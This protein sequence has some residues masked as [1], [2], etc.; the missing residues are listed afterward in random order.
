[1][2]KL[3]FSRFLLICVV[4]VT[5]VASLIFF[6]L[7]E[8]RI[9]Q[10]ISQYI[11]NISLTVS[12]AMSYPLSS[13]KNF[14]SDFNSV[15]ELRKENSK[16]NEKL[17]ILEPNEKKLK[18]LI[19]ENE[20]LRASLDIKNSFA[21]QTVLTGKVINRST[22]AWLDWI[23]LDVGHEDGVF[24][25]M[26]VLSNG[27]LIGKITQV[28]SKFSTVDLLTNTGKSIEI[29]IKISTSTGD[30]YGILTGFDVHKNSY[31]ITKLNKKLDITKGNPV[32]TSGLDGQTVANVKVGEVVEIISEDELNR[33]V[34]V[35]PGANFDD[36]AYVTLIGE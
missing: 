2:R 6:L 29:P 3:G 22:L 27:Y 12:S 17:S 33:T 8:V 34:Y 9:R 13:A 5:C 4:T 16:L 32:F 30:I 1:M 26:L 15:D 19:S 14:L 23:S 20:S 24:E 28:T 10:S 35:S 18:D 31:L 11:S 36:L 25:N 21:S 7:K